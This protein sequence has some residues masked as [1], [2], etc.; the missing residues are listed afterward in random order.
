[1]HYSNGLIISE[2]ENISSVLLLY[3]VCLAFFQ[4]FVG[5]V[6]SF[7]FFFFFFSLFLLASCISQT[8]DSR[9]QTWKVQSSKNFMGRSSDFMVYE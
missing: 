2:S 9:L 4:V 8:F 3:L 1:M 5:G 6:F 7:S